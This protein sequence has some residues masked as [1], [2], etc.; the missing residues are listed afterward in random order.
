MRILQVCV[1]LDGGGIDR[2]L[3]NYCT[4]I[5][6]ISF[7]FA[8][9]ENKNIGILEAPIRS[10]GCNIYHI[11]RQRK[12]VIN[13]YRSLKK[14]MSQNQYDAIHVH[15]GY[16]SLIA[17]IAAKNSKIKTRIVHAHI[18]NVPEKR[19]EKITRKI[20]TSLVKYYAT[21]L[22]ACGIDAAKWLWG[23]RLYKNNNVTIF[24]NAIDTRDYSYSIEKRTRI[25]KQLGLSKGQLVIGHVGRLCE[26]KNQIR[27][28]EIF[29]LL[30]QQVNNSF[31]ILIGRGGDQEEEIRLNIAK[32][33]LDDCVS[34]LGVR[35]D[36]PELLNAID[37]FVF[38]SKYEG[39]PFT[40]IETQCNGL[41]SIS[42]DNVTHHVKVS[43]FLFFLPLEAENTEWCNQILRLSTV[44]HSESAWK[45]VRNAGYDIVIEAA[46]LKSFYIGEI[47]KND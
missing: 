47:I 14:I 44:G 16:K 45:E 26:Q 46:K 42:S 40:L 8:I 22:V 10:L 39:L 27:L 15:L 24:N 20:F 9:I 6:D 2:Y 31:L 29:H 3:L 36:V 21:A 37:V 13:N 33:K 28:I 30:H 32:H 23:E 12:G 11:P 17:L 18:A 19:I 35:E 38:P 4:R 7:D 1:D 43:D 34:L 5:K 25:R 41:P